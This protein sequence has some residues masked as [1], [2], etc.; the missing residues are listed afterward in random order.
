MR[1]A[2]AE[3]RLLTRAWREGTTL[4]ERRPKP[5]SDSSRVPNIIWMLWWQGIESAPRLVK[6]CV[7]SWERHNPSWNLRILDK[8]NFH[9]WVSL[10]IPDRK[11]TNLKVAH[12]S[13]HIRLRLLETHGG[14]W[15]DPT[16]LCMTPLD[17]WLPQLDHGGFFAFRWN[18]DDELRGTFGILRPG[19]NRIMAS[20]FLVAATNDY[21]IEQLSKIF[22]DYWTLNDL[23]NN[24]K[25]IVRIVVKRILG[26][27]P[28]LARYWSHPFITK[29]LRVHP[30]L[31]VNS[32]F[33]KLVDDDPRVAAEWRRASP[34]SARPCHA[35]QELGPEAAM[36]GEV[37]E[38]FLG[39]RA[40]IQKLN[41][42]IDLE[43]SPAN[44]ALRYFLFASQETSRDSYSATT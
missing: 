18:R 36:T 3:A 11:F 41:W 21:A 2:M 42:R 26:R 37:S 15:V 43:S 4:R 25:R 20:W 7:R 12:Q 5:T 28:L 17:E 23:N 13:A 1:L 27:E 40:P 34:L 9:D 38:R 14:V 30:Y 22:S 31:V 32:L 6:Q 24:G 10:T 44:S 8:D 35:L 33:T 39:L 19:R 29:V 16:C